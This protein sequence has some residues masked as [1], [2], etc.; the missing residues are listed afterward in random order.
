MTSAIELSSAILRGDADIRNHHP[1]SASGALEELAPG[2]AFVTAFANVSAFTGVDAAGASELLLVDTGSQFHADVIHRE[3]R[4]WTK[5]PLRTAVYTHGHVDHVFGTGQFEAENAANEWGPVNV[6]AHAHVARRFDRYVATAGWNGAINARQFQVPG[7]RF[8][9]TYRY[10]DETYT[11]QRDVVVAGA[12]IQLRHAKGETDDHTWTWMPS[13]KTLCCGDL[14]I[15]CSPNAGN[16]QKVQRFA[17]EWAAAL[18]AM[19]DMGAELLFPGHGLPIAGAATI[20]TVLCD[21]AELLRSLHDQSLALMNDGARLDDLIHG[22]VVPAHLVNKPYLQPIYDEPEF[23]VRNVWR[24][25]GG[26]YDGNPATLKPAPAA[27]LAE[28]LAELAGG[29]AVLAI[30]AQSLAA[31][32]KDADLRLAGHLA[33]TAR[34]AA[35]ND[36][37]VVA[38]HAEVF[39]A[40]RDAATSTMAK[41][42][43]AWA[44]GESRAALAS[45]GE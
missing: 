13:T 7:M 27:A 32:G 35:P 3:V 5:A 4:R 17:L 29:A 24:R 12:Q 10:P 20:R 42:I 39:E 44:A 36:P 23:V 19:A 14:F 30:R 26:W 40:K 43:F 33:E 41:G 16:P 1:F 18:E 25:Y 28:E 38:A 34:M 8:P 6:V 37:A 22:V 9:T 2:V 45:P 21:T 31:S 11:D 15:W